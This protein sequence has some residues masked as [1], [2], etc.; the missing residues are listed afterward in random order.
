MRSILERG[1]DRVADERDSATPPAI[2]HANVRGA[3]YYD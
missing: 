3:S 2:R 1:L